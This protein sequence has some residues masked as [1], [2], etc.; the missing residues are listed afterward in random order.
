MLISV[1]IG[2]TIKHDL[3]GSVV[4]LVVKSGVCYACFT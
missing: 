2:Q 4:S 1:V 3:T